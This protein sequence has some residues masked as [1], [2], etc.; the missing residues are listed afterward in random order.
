MPSSSASNEMVS[1]DKTQVVQNHIKQLS[2]SGTDDPSSKD[3][4]SKD[5]AAENKTGSAKKK[6]KGRLC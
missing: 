1:D 3:S 2:D 4:A 6:G 5:P